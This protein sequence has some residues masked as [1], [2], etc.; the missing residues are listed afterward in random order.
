M[1]KLKRLKAWRK[2][3]NFIKNTPQKYRNHIFE[4]KITLITKTEE[5]TY[6]KR[7]IGKPSGK[8]IFQCKLLKQRYL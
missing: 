4:E 3:I 6:F 1:H 5:K 8:V 2:K 7:V